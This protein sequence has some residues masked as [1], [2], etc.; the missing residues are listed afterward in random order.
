MAHTFHDGSRH[1]HRRALSRCPI[2]QHGSKT[3]RYGL[4]PFDRKLREDPSSTE[5]FCCQKAA[6]EDE[7]DLSA[8]RAVKKPWP[9]YR[10]Q[11]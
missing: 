8:E 6:V 4:D 5:Q 3:A 7:E 9:W 11:I 10:R 1:G 2:A